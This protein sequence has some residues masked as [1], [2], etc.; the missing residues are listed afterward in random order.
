MSETDK[1]TGKADG[2]LDALMAP[3]TP[4]EKTGTVE[5]TD[6]EPV[7]ETAAPVL[8]VNEKPEGYVEPLPEVDMSRAI[9]PVEDVVEFRAKYSNFSM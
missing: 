2:G 1:V 6:T 9:D 4:T 8:K 3:T 7:Q 5:A